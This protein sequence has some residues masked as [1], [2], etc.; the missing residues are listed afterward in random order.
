MSGETSPPLVSPSFADPSALSVA[1]VINEG[2]H[3][4]LPALRLWSS[5]TAWTRKLISHVTPVPTL[6]ALAAFASQSRS[7]VVVCP[8]YGSLTLARELPAAP[9]RCVIAVPPLDDPA[10][11]GP[12]PATADGPR[13]VVTNDALAA[14]RKEFIRV[15]NA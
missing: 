13:V 10:P 15:L 3:L 14:V 4:I 9:W 1:V 7:T 8:G 5:S 12:W 11:N 2:G 6:A